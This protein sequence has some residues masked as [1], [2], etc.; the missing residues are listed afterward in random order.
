MRIVLCV[1]AGVLLIDFGTG[2]LH[3][4]SK[5]TAVKDAKAR[6]IA[7]ILLHLSLKNVG[8]HGI[9]EPNGGHQVPMFAI[10]PSNWLD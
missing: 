10:V 4:A 5:N 1:A 9:R 2:L 6:N 8:S 7:V 3:Y